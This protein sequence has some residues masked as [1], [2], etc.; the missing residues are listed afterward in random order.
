MVVRQKEVKITR[1][2]QGRISS[3][4]DFDGKTINYG[5]D[6]KGNLTKVTDREGRENKL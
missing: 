5:Y 1:D 2:S 3:I 4:S 6:D